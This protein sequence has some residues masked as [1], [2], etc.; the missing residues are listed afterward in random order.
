M[1]NARVASCN[2]A[3]YPTPT[4]PAKPKSGQRSPFGP[5]GDVFAITEALQMP[6]S[7]SA[8]AANGKLLPNAT[9][10]HL[11]PA[12][13]SQFVPLVTSTPNPRATATPYASPT[14]VPTLAPATPRS[15]VIQA[16]HW[17]SSKMPYQLAEFRNDGAFAGGVAEW[18][19]NLDVANRAAALLRARGYDVQVIPATVPIGCQADAFIALHADGDPSASAHGYKA[20][21]PHYINNPINRRFLADLYIEYGAATSLA[22]D[23]AITRNMSG[24]YAFYARRQPYAV[25]ARTP[26]LIL[27]MG[28]LSN[29]SDRQFL[30]A[31]ADVAALGVANGIDRFLQGK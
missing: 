7:P 30:T 2:E 10:P 27:E 22:R 24:Y 28:Y 14:A 16:G 9:A 11:P 15:V 12:P 13:A 3:A 29:L 25:D 18:Q 4:P 21:Y 6:T 23:Y 26:M 1:G 5:N 8:F 31:R 19:L 20:A 17:Q